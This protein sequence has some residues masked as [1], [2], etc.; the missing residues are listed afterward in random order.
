[1]KETPSRSMEDAIVT[2]NPDSIY[3]NRQVVGTVSGA[4][5]EQERQ[6][7]FSEICD[8]GKLTKDQ[9]FDYKRLTLRIRSVEESIG[10]WSD[11]TTSKQ[12][13]LRGVICDRIH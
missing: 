9:P 8:T 11:G 12:A 5:S 7:V 4:V 2:R 3:Q 10:I 13:V 1:M 6:V